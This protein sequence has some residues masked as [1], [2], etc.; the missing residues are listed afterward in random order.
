LKCSDYREHGRPQK[1]GKVAPLVADLSKL[2]NVAPRTMKDAAAAKRA[3]L[4]DEVRDGTISASKAAGIGRGTPT[5]RKP[6][7]APAA[8]VTAPPSEELAET[9]EAVAILAEEND[10]LNDRLAVEAMDATEDEKLKAATTIA[11]LRAELKT[12]HAELKAVKASRDHYMREN[13][14]LKRANAA[15]QRKLKKLEV[16]A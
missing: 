10:R 15:L 14:D 4:L 2:A 6:V 12:A 16:A 3:G 8:P 13:A 7:P 1:G 11:E 9:Q 5:P